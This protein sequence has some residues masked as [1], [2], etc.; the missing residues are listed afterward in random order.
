MI[1]IHNIFWI[2]DALG[3]VHF[4]KRVATVLLVWYGGSHCTLLYFTIFYSVVFYLAVHRCNLAV[5][6]G[7][8]YLPHY[9]QGRRENSRGP[10]QNLYSAPL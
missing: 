7:K 1:E 8:L 5:V 3:E 2:L 6:H 4:S 10:G 9:T